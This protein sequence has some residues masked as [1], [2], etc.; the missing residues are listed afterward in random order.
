MSLPDELE[1]ILVGAGQ[2]PS[3]GN[4]PTLLNRSHLENICIDYDLT[5][6]CGKN[7]SVIDLAQS[8]SF[9]KAKR[10]ED[11]EGTTVNHWCT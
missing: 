8:T 3:H 11:L 7:K 2:N 5:D 9:S 4:E 10:L 6:L 1:L